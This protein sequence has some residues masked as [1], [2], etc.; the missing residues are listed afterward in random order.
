VNVL[1]VSALYHDAAAALVVDGEVVAAAQEERFTRVKNDASLPV[2]AMEYCLDAGGVPPDGIDVV[3]Y[4]EKPLTSFVRVL[5]T[6]T[7][8]GPKGF[9]TFPRAMDEALRNK[10]WVAYEIERALRDLGYRRPGETVFA[11]HHTSHAAAAFYPSPFESACVLTFD[12]VGE[13]ATSS[14]GVGRGRR[15]DLLAEMRF[16][17]SIGLLYSAFTYSAGFKVNSGEYKLM[18]LAPFGSP[19]YR[20]RILDRVVDLRDDGSFTLDLS[21]F[22]FLAGRRMTN[23]RFDL[24]FDGPPRHPD[25][26]ITRREC[27]LARS[28]QDVIEE[29]VLRMAHHGHELTGERQAVLGGGVALNCVA[30]G[31][32]LREGPFDDIWVQPAAGDAGSALGCALWAWHEVR[33]QERPDRSG[34]DAMRGS[35]LGPEPCAGDVAEL[36]EAEGRPFERLDDPAVRAAKVAELLASGAVVGVCSGPMEFGPRALGNRSILADARDDTM[37]RRLNVKIKNRESFRPFAP[38]VLEEHVSEWFELD[39]PSPYMSIVAPVRG[40]VSVG[41]DGHDLDEG[42]APPPPDEVADL[43]GRLAGVRSPVP[44]VTHVDGSARIQTV[45]PER[46]PELERTLRAFLELTGCPVLV[47]TSFNVRGE[48][49]VAGAEDAYRCFMTTDMD[50]LLLDDCLLDKAAQP[51]WLGEAAPTIDD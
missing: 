19:R 43:A 35:L 28:I 44:A 8:I 15:I 45:D 48:P 47:N 50:W 1:G 25:R 34:K 24:L 37:Q 36:L 12:G 13:W 16:P 10:L 23:Q 6:F 20:D 39:R 33:Q 22:D 31:R 32:L 41:D 9:R 29:I 7:A 38:V 3:A 2:H 18:G 46:H 4:Y 5:K 49:I 27:D 42:D 40:A 17:H 11:E 30:N 26:P 51:E 14:I 21:Y